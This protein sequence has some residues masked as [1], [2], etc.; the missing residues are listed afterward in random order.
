MIRYVGNFLP[1]APFLGV[2]LMVAGTVHAANPREEIQQRAVLVQANLSRIAES[3]ATVAYALETVKRYESD[4]GPLFLNAATQ[5]GVPREPSDKLKL[6]YAI[7]DIQQALIEQVYT[8]ENLKRF[9]RILAGVKFETSSYFPGAVAP[10]V[11]TRVTN[12]V[13][14]NASQPT[15][16]GSPVS[17]TDNPARRPTGSYLA[18]GTY[19]TVTVP[20]S[21]INKGYQVRVG[22]H[23]WDLKKKPIIKRLD[24]ISLLFPITS[25]T[26][27]IASPMGGGIYIEVP[28]QA[29]AGIQKIKV[30][31]AVKAPFF[32]A[33]SFDKTTV[34]EW[35]KEIR[36]Y[37]APWADFESDK[38][39]MQ[40][41]SLWIRQLNDPETLMEDW[42]KAMDG[43]SELFGH[44]LVR[45][46]TVL[47][48]QTDVTMRGAANFPGYPQS[49]YAFNPH[50][51]QLAKSKHAWMVK[52]PQFADWTVFHEVGHSQQISK[53]RGEVEAVVNL[54]HAAI[55]NN[56]F[57]MPLDKAFGESVGGKSQISLDEAAIMWMVTENFRQGKPMN[58]T[59]KPGDEMKYQHRGYGKYVEIAY[60]FGWEALGRFWRGENERWKPGDRVPQN[61]APTDSR[62]LQMSQAAGVD[63]TPL[64]HFWGVQPR[65]PQVLARSIRAAGLKPSS[66][67][68]ERL[69]HYMTIIPKNNAE[70]RRHTKVVYPRGLGKA[71]DPKYGEGWYK[72]WGPKYN[73]SHANAAKDAIQAILRQYF[74]SDRLS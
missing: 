47:Y 60:L 5:K 21:M 57:G 25:A 15:A 51:P 68:K 19:A 52:G 35:R 69:E 41:P 61:S 70:F 6:E 49:N 36:K 7:F 18:P 26:T 65:N 1:S 48:L 50:Q 23:S 29:N 74:N 13:S 39:M 58:A 17:G 66:R 73:E 64:I 32:S 16:W 43:V 4:V 46:K 55:M 8:P 9:H 42:D 71:K 44:P 28:Y 45:S 31:G 53:F 40:V 3:P 12:I 56:K 27:P 34:A 30:Q 67:I 14:I 54:P 24:R 63:L 11:S 10:P 37:P 72:A 22:A 62:I 59:N 33:R 20:K 2:A 38:F